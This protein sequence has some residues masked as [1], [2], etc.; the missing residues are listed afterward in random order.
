MA[1]LLHYLSWSPR[2]YKRAVEEVRTTFSS[3]DEIAFG[4]KLNSC[5]F[6]RACL[7]EALRITPPGGG[8]L[9]RVVEQGGTQIDGDYVPAGCEVG[10]GIYAMHRDA[11]NWPNPSKY[12]PERWLEKDKSEKR[13][14]K[15]ARLPYFPFNIGP[16]S[17]VGKPLAL[18]EVMLTFAHIL[19]EFD[20]RRTD[21]DELWW[22]SD[23][24]DPP[25]YMLRDHVTGQKEGPVLYF[26]TRFG[27]GT[28][29]HM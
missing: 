11:R 28:P 6:L 4:A 29:C 18:A 26:R 8:P 3:A 21:A 20:L 7:D 13:L 25:E 22:E 16:R 17:C 9:W 12:T 19:W 5:I 15:N 1:A 27:T 23:D 14:D 10:A 24:A 2:C